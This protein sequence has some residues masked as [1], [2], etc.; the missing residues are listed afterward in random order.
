MEAND[1]YCLLITTCSDADFA[2]KLA[3]SVVVEKLAACVNIVNGVK[4]VYQWQQ[5]IEVGQELL[6]IIKTKR[7][8]IEL[9]ENKLKELHPY[10]LPEIIT[11]PIEAGSSEYLNWLAENLK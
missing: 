7:Q 8:L 11:V 4:S 2:E 3:E 5:K 9:V 1:K 10:E 6:L